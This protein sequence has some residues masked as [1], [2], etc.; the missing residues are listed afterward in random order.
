MQE[1]E[2]KRAVTASIYA[3]HIRPHI[4]DELVAEHRERPFG[5]HTAHLQAVLNY[6]RSDLDTTRPLYVV[7]SRGQGP[8]R[9]TL[10]VHPRVRGVPIAITGE[11]FASEQEAEHTI[12]L[13]RLADLADPQLSGV[14]ARAEWS[15]RV[16]HG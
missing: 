10:G 3:A 5:P 2:A 1:E 6:L 12:F 13:R 16:S 11:V 9:L 15:L 14:V 8:R 7:V 4:T